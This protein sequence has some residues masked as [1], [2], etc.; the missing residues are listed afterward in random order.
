MPRAPD[1][2]A[3]PH[4]LTADFFLLTSAEGGW[5]K[6]HSPI[7][8]VKIAVSVNSMT[9]GNSKAP[10]VEELNSNGVRTRVMRSSPSPR[11]VAGRRQNVTARG[12]GPCACRRLERAMRRVDSR[13]RRTCQ[14]E[15][16][17]ACE[18]PVRAA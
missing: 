17:F 8:R 1:T 15:V 5:N 14:D 16:A 12:C 6:A 3:L 7:A 13:P 2:I 9:L 4:P 11:A 10:R 18:S